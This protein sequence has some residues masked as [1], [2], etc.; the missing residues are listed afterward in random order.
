MLTLARPVAG[1]DDNRP[2]RSST[3]PLAHFH[4]FGR[5][6]A[7]SS[8]SFC[9]AGQRWSSEILSMRAC[10]QKA[11][12]SFPSRQPLPPF[13]GDL[14]VRNQIGIELRAGRRQV[15]LESNSGHSHVTA[16]QRCVVN[17]RA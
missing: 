3:R 5:F 10:A 4:G 7:S 15:S 12:P 17:P 1:T 14:G 2:M 6:V 9:F 8:F 16:I 11:L 13:I